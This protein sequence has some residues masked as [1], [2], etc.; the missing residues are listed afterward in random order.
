VP[1]RNSQTELLRRLMRKHRLHEG[2]YVRVAKR[3]G[4]DQSYVSKVASGKQPSPEIC[5]ALLKELQRI[6]RR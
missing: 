1:R 5:R 6:E 4:V 2:V 3:L